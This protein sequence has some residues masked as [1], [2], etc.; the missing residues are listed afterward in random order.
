MTTI[1]VK[2][3]VYLEK[4]KKLAAYF[5]ED[6]VVR[7]K[8]GGTPKKQKDQIRESGLLNLLIPEEFGGEGQHWS[9]ALEI[10]REFSK[11]DAALGHLFGYHS[12]FVSDI[13]IKGTKEQ[14]AFFYPQSVQQNAFW[15]NSSNPLNESLLGKR[16]GKSYLLNGTKAFSSGSPDSQYLWL[17]FNDAVTGQYMNGVIPTKKP[18]I[19]VRDNW[20]AIGQRQTGSG[21]VDFKNV[22]L[23]EHEIIDDFVKNP[24]PFS[25]LGPSLSQLIL[26]NVFIGSAFGAMAEA[27]KY[28]TSKTR[29]WLTAGVEKASHDPGILR[30]YGELWIQSKAASVLADEAA[31]LLDQ[32]WEKEKELTEEE[33][34]ELAVS[35][36]TANVFSGKAA[37]DVTSSIFEVMGARSVN[38]EYGYDRFWRNVRTHTLHNPAE[39][40]L[41]NIGN[42]VLNEQYPTPN[43]YA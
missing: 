3:E 30:K 35:V 42:W 9:T 6:A 39:Y 32:V 40:K 17:S 27:K 19:S 16:Q 36:A 18:G 5:A 34:G 14:Q 12:L 20:N 24:T 41:R 38:N 1:G 13:Q 7:D 22:E 11:T 26:T 43:P 28:T 8:L 10:V 37:L 29:P 23:E 15:G 33:R 2:S 4:A 21:K 31:K 25:T